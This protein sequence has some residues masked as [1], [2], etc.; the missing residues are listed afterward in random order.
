MRPGPL[1]H[2]TEPL[3]D[4]DTQRPHPA[5]HRLTLTDFRSYDHVRIDAGAAS[6][7]LTGPNGAGKTNLLEA[8][9]FLVPGRGLRGGALSDVGRRAP[10]EA[11]GRPWA[12]AALVAHPGGEMAIGTGIEAP[13]GGARE[14][15]AV[16]IAGERVSQQAA[17]GEYLAALWLTPQMDGLFQGP[18]ADRR[19]FLDRI[20]LAADGAHAGRIS[21]YAHAMRERARLLGEDPKRGPGRGRAPDPAWLDALEET[22]VEKGVAVAAARLNIAERLATFAAHPLSAS[23]EGGFPAAQV[24]IEGEVEDWLR[25]GV[26]LDAEDRF[27]GALKASRARDGEFG[28]AAVGPH[29]SELTVRHLGTGRLARDGST[30]EQKALLIGLVLATARMIRDDHDIHSGTGHGGGGRQGVPVLLLDEV[31]A[32]LDERRRHQLFDEVRA[33]GAQV[34]FTGTD[35]SLFSGFVSGG[36][37]AGGREVLSL[38]VADGRIG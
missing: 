25:A 5:V 1:E 20:V 16:H 24:G 13:K 2:P 3:R 4:G 17:L 19:R 32:H 27:R 23:E 35:E 38:R 14:R 7:V 18:A 30:G 34:W 36:R 9:S 31:A 10:D 8:I 26:A 37:H 12:V 33:L 11:Q 15:R 28:G 22:M 29:R 6:V 21:A